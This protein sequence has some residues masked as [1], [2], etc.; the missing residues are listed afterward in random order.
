M[1]K[2]K[3]T[4]R[5]NI[6]IA[7]V[8]IIGIILLVRL[9]QLQIVEGAE[10][11]EQ[12]N[13]RLTRETEIKAARGNIRDSSGNRL[14]S[15]TI[16]YNVEIH[17][18]K[19][20]NDSL[21]NSLLLLAQTLE[22]NGDKYSDTFPI[23]VNDGNLTFKDGVDQEKW[24]SANKV[25]SSYDVNQSFDFFK[26]RYSVNSDNI[27]DARKIVALR[28]YI[29]QNGY[30]NTKA[31]TLASNISNTSFAKINEMG[32]SFPSL[33]NSCIT[34]FRICRTYFSKRIKR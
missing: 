27:D 19:I 2:R 31:V 26:K 4:K 25:D 6:T 8:Y 33:R 23:V 17:K 9:F 24:K 20:D 12:S 18:T 1:S 11:R 7:F 10:Y 29:E 28:Y 14:V 21:N 34:Y 3:N 16:E 15:T 5:Y 30:S 13:T 32:A 22:T